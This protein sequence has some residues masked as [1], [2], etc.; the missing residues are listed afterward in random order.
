MASME[1]NDVSVAATAY[2]DTFGHS[3]PIEVLRLFERRPGPLIMEIRQAIAL[4]RAVPG[5]RALSRASD[6]S[7]VATWPPRV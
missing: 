4:G 6:L 5:W 2:R 3:V 1:S 7:A